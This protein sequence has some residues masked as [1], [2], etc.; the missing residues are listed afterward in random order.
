MI[1]KYT[2][3]RKCVCF[4]ALM[5][6]ALGTS[7]ALAQTQEKPVK[8][9]E[10]RVIAPQ[11]EGYRVEESTTGTKT[12][13]PLREVPR[14]IQVIPQPLIRDQGAV[15]LDDAIRNV[16]GLTRSSS[17]NYGFFNNY[18][19]RGLNLNFLRD[20][21]PDGFTINGYART[22]T[23]VEQIEVL[24]GPG[25]ALYGSGDP[26]GSINLI[27]KKPQMGPAY[28]LRTG[29]G[30]FDT[31]Y[32]QGDAT[33]SLVEDKLAYRL[34]GN[35][36][37]SRGFRDISNQTVEVLPRLLWKANSKH[38]L[39]F[40]FDYRELIVVADPV[41]IPFN[42]TGLVSVPASTKLYSPLSTT[43]TQIYRG[44]IAHAWE[45][46]NVLTIRQNF[47]YMNHGLH[48]LREQA[49][50]VVGNSL[51][52]RNLRDQTDRHNEILYQVEPVWT[53]VAAGIQHTVLSGFEF[54]QDRISTVRRTAALPNIADIRNPIF[55]E[56]ALP[57]L[58]FVKNFDRSIEANQ[59]GLYL[60]DQVKF[61]EQWQVRLAG[62][63]D[64]FDVADDGQKLAGQSATNESNS[65]DRLS[66]E[67]G[68]VYS[69]SKMTSFYGGI[70]KSHRAILTTESNRTA[71]A[72][73]SALQY[74]LG[75]R[76]FFWDGKLATNL[77]VYE[78]TRENFLQTILGQ[79][80]PIPVG[81]QRTRGV[82]LDLTAQPVRGW[83]TIATYSWQQAKYVTLLAPNTAFQDHTVIGVP[84]TNASLFTSYEFQEGA[85]KGFGVGGGVTYQAGFFIDMANRQKVPDYILGDLVFFYRQKKY[86]VQVNVY[87]IGDR[88][89]FRNGV[90]GGALPG[91]PL[92]ALA[93][94]RWK[95]S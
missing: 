42:G 80:D 91:Y 14:S 95:F 73:E 54:H 40:D 57:G 45:V 64:H 17:S 87:N 72:P 71:F 36:Y 79:P 76:S 83:S 82:E 46:S 13:T 92:S 41:G 59:Y 20:G 1:S 89:W 24:K 30:S 55:P 61:N 75:N 51:T 67:A 52:A 48:L 28:E 9:E 35:Y 78:V 86:D 29:I 26:G 3:P 85:V 11:E 63:Y 60:Q 65:A 21:I 4:I 56:M 12:E 69:P 19:S 34:I 32:G 39:R 47:V 23:D 81:K 50:L 70:A 15:V 62:R 88:D 10:I 22:L 53:F 37:N 6:M 90:N 84:R 77:A 8:I 93:T 58:P 25:S 18:L 31:Y 7:L 27:T 74:E 49:P 94:L 2:G 38:T 43:N 16:S 66:G 44:L 5:S 33:G 68:L